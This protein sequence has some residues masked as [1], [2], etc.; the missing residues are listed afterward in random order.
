[1]NFPVNNLGKVPW[2]VQLVI[3][4]DMVIQWYKPMWDNGEQHWELKLSHQAIKYQ[5]WKH[6]KL[7]R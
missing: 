6:T 7:A 1:M 3:F 2:V 4:P 5:V